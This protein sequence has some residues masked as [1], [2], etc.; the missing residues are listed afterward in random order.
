MLFFGMCFSLTLTRVLA[1]F[2]CGHVTNKFFFIVLKSTLLASFAEE[3]SMQLD[4]FH[5]M[6]FANQTGIFSGVYCIRVAY[7]ID[8]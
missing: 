1:I 3:K 5:I 4:P 7:T 2:G 8:H 6:A